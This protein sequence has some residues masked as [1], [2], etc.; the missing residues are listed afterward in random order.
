METC[1]ELFS[2]M[3]N[4]NPGISEMAVDVLQEKE[5]NIQKVVDYAVDKNIDFVIVGPEAPLEAGLVNELN[6]KNIKCYS[7]T[8]Q[9]AYRTRCPT[10]PHPA[11]ERGDV[12]SCP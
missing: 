9:A 1:V 4:L 11:G 10:F 6:K 5:T 3:S 2:V 7:P 8:K 12:T